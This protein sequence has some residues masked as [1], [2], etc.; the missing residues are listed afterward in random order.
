LILSLTFLFVGYSEL[1]S[2][3]N[4]SKSKDNADA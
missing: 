4:L 1:L 2:L 3:E